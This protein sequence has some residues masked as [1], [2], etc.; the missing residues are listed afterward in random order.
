M[1]YEKHFPVSG[2]PCPVP[3]PEFMVPDFLLWGYLKECVY[4][5][6]PHTIRETKRAIRNEIATINRGLLHLVL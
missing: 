4:K 1:S 2:I 6:G 3:S 5:N